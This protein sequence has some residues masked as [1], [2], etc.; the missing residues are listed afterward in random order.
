M[1]VIITKNNNKI[2]ESLIPIDFLLGCGERTHHN[3]VFV[4]C[5]LTTCIVVRHLRAVAPNLA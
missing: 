3:T 4:L 2:E 5:S 1:E